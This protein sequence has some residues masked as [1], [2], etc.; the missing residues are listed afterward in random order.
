MALIDVKGIQIRGISTVVPQRVEYNMDYKLLSVE[1]RK[2]LIKTT[3]VVSRRVSE[4]ITT[5]DL[6]IQ[7]ANHLFKKTAWKRTEIDLLIFVTQ[8]RDYYLPSTGVIAQNK[9]QL[10]TS[11]MAFDVGLGCSGYVY[12]LSIVAS[13]LNSGTIKKAILLAGDVS[14][15]S[16]NYKDRSAYPLFGDAGSATF[17]EKTKEGNRWSFDLHS[18]GSG[19]DAIKIKDGGLRNIPSKASFKEKKY[20]G[21]IIR[22]GFNLAL[23]GMDIFNFSVTTMPKSIRQFLIKKK[24]SFH[25]IDFFVMHQANLIMN[26]TIRKKL[27]VEKEKVPYT[28]K[29]YGNTSSA[30]IPL[31]MSTLNYLKTS[32]HKLLLSGFGVGLSWAN[33]II[34][35]SPIPYLLIN[36]YINE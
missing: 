21:E 14:T 36:D 34:E 33:A 8:S 26:E 31:T 1:E 24:T 17:I 11:C 20:E 27:K 28:L 13:M 35:N 32:K 7:A 16:C 2:M 23:N 5:S 12:G 9:L 30:S 29:N 19:E 22:N 10:P 18:D 3:G 15:I 25:E 6:A 4:G